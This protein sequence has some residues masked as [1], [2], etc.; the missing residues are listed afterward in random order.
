[1]KTVTT[2]AVLSSIL[3][4]GEDIAHYTFTFSGRPLAEL[5]ASKIAIGQAV[6]VKIS[7]PN[8]NKTVEQNNTF[9]LLWTIYW[10]SGLPSD[11]TKTSLRNR[12]KFEYGISEYYELKDGTVKGTLK[13]IS[14]YTLKDL[15]ILI[16]GTIREMLLAGVNDKRFQDMIQEWNEYKQGFIK[17][18]TV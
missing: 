2:K 5:K 18:K 13:S 7:D 6:E 12:L 4:D 1:M 16:D 8:K 11:Q 10:N 15:Q 14:K 9:H 17:T 3:N